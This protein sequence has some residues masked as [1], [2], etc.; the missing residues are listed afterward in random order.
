MIGGDIDC[1]VVQHFKTIVDKILLLVSSTFFLNVL[2]RC[3][4]DSESVMPPKK[5]PYGKMVKQVSV[6][7]FSIL[8]GT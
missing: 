7:P 2:S 6:C 4:T 1:D 5:V 3:G 8:H